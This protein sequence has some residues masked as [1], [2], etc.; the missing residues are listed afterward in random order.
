M[1]NVLRRFN[2]LEVDG[3]V[4]LLLVILAIP[5]GLL[6]VW[7]MSRP[8]QGEYLM[9]TR[10]GVL[11][12]ITVYAFSVGFGLSGSKQSRWWGRM[13]GRLSLLAPFIFFF[14]LC[15]GIIGAVAN[16]FGNG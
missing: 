11:T 2:Q 8:M 1:R 9:A 16:A 10:L 14:L 15:S 4:S 3:Y 7:L 5:S 13:C 6:V 12:T